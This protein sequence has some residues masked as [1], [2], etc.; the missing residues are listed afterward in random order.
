MF[1]KVTS[2]MESGQSFCFGNGCEVW[3]GTESVALSKIDKEM[4][5]ANVFPL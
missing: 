4:C 5:E 2:Q 3:V 1:A